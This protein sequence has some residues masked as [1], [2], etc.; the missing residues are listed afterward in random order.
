MVRPDS[1]DVENTPKTMLK[2]GNAM[3]LQRHTAGAEMQPLP[4]RS[5]AWTKATVLLRRVS[6]RI[7]PAS[8][9]VEF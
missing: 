7:L 8:P 2:G 3:A 5:E 4:L 6:R 9:K 1:D